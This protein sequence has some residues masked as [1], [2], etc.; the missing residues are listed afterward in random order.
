MVLEVVL[1]VAYAFCG[2]LVAIICFVGWMVSV[3][4]SRKHDDDEGKVNH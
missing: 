3:L 2:W 1:A 4:A